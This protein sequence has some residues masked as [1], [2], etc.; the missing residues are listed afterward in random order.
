MSTKSLL[1][2][3]MLHNVQN[4]TT[5]PIRKRTGPV[6]RRIEILEDRTNPVALIPLGN[7]FLAAPA[8]G[9]VQQNDLQ[10]AVRPDGTGFVTV[11]ESDVANPGTPNLYYQLYDA[12]WQAIGS[13][14]AV[15]P[16]TS[17]FVQNNAEI[18]I[19]NAGNFVIAWE[20]ENQFSANSFDIDA[21]QFGPTGTPLGASFVVDTPAAGIDQQ[22]PRSRSIPRPGSS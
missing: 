1:R 14:A 6:G 15:D 10:V 7:D 5:S 18:S 21:R 19:D 9:T 20:T 22:N 8:P 12:N 3:L 4:R 16:S 2:R 17:S 11:Y 13:A